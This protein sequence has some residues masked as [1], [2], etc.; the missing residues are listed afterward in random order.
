MG[1]EA[2]T[3]LRGVT[4]M[5]ITDML[6]TDEG[7]KALD[8]LS[9]R[10]N[11]SP[12]Q[13]RSAIDALAPAV[14]SGLRA[15]TQSP[16]G[17]AGLLGALVKGDHG[18]YL[19]GNEDGIVDDGNAI[20]GH[21]FGSKDVSRGVAAEAAR[22]TGLG[23]GTM[24]QM[25][26]MVAAMV[27]GALGKNLMGDQA[28]TKG[29]GLAD[30]LGQVLGAS[31]GSGA[32]GGSGNLGDI[33]G[34]MLGGGIGGGGGGGLGD[35]LGGLAGGGAPKTGQPTGGGGLGDLLGGLAGGGGSKTSGQAPG[36][37][38]I[39]GGLFGNQAPPEV[40]S[41]AS[42]RA[43]D[44]LGSMLGGKSPRGAKGD[45]MLDKAKQDLGHA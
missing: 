10:F 30:V 45:K 13:T 9:R 2:L 19:D 23:D 44:T 27:M 4:P 3:L 22:E 14:T 28:S 26:P 17:L 41:A 32:G 21:L 35:L 33:L 39:L 34:Q 7:T 24:K 29:G 43:R 38:D 5:D 40:R 6:G 15:E 18:R 8:V 20:L 16:D 36:L 1:L 31:G 25:L 37:D 11:L 42:E 12:A